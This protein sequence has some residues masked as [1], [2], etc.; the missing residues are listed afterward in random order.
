MINTWGDV[1]SASLKSIWLGVANF[2]PTFLAAIVIAIVGWII[3]SI[4]FKLVS[5]LIKLAKVDNALRSA[6][7]ERVL[8]RAGIRLDAGA[9]IGALVKWFFIIVFL[10]AAFDVL[11]L[12]QITA[13]LKDVVLGYLPQVIVAVLIIIVAAVVSEAMHKLVVSTSKAANIKTANFAGTIT[14]WA[15]WIFAVLAAIMQLGIAVSFINT[16]FTG[17]IIA[18]SLALG[19]AFGLGGQ[20][21]AAKYIE[22]VKGE[23]ADR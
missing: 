11:G 2:I 18:I 5:Q 6:G 1:L 8:Q 3:G 15:I 12:T 7:F 4:L 13:F 22:K 23:V 9:F 20:D 10:V 14:K 19:L 17:V 21:A 16:L